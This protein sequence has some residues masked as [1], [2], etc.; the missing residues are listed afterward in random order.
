MNAFRF[1]LILPSL[2]A[3]LA[4]APTRSEAG[5]G[6]YAL[7]FGDQ[8]IIAIDAS[9][10]TTTV[11]TTH[12]QPRSLAI[13]SSGSIYVIGETGPGTGTIEKFSSSGQDLGVFATKP[14]GLYSI[15]ID[16]AGNVYSEEF[17]TG[18]IEKFSP[19]GQ[20]LGA[21][22]SG[23]TTDGSG[24]LGFGPNGNLYVYNYHGGVTEYFPSGQLI[25]TF[26]SGV[27]GQAVAFDSSGNVYIN[28]DGGILEYSSS[29]QF[30]GMFAST[31]GNNVS[32]L[33]FDSSGNL[34]ASYDNSGTYGNIEKFSP[35]GQDLGNFAGVVS[36]DLAS[37][38]LMPSSV[39]EPA[40][41]VMVGVSLAAVSGFVRLHRDR[42][43]FGA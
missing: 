34:Y 10:R 13:D 6:L 7:G 20:D 14:L 37:A 2:L 42:A 31:G 18:V 35:T 24:Q 23:L 22:V 32:G 38:P 1:R 27:F 16:M 26:A 12:F 43:G 40:S 15:A 5:F 11:A 39:P 8:A 19:T 3:L 41:L 29:G 17:Q 33:A 4:I 36:N 30:L 9:G 28:G 21:F 25:G